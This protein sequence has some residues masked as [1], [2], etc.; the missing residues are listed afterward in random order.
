M[1]TARRTYLTASLA[2]AALLTG[3]VSRPTLFKNP[4]PNLN[5]STSQLKVDAAARFPYKMNAPRAAE[6]RAAATIGYSLNRLEVLNFT[7]QDWKDV[8]IWVNRQYVCHVPVMEDRKL[9]EIHFPML[10]DAAGN[11]FPRNNSQIRVETVEIVRDG[12]VYAINSYIGD[13]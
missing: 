8:E 6:P 7:G 10:Y 12:K 11:A 13:R 1:S 5:L 9:K 2:L 3:C 4:D